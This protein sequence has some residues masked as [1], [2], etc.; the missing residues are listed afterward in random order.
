MKDWWWIPG[1]GTFLAL[2]ELVENNEVKARDARREME[3][4]DGEM[5]TAE[6][7]IRL[8]NTA[9]SQVGV[10]FLLRVLLLS[11]Q[12]SVQRETLNY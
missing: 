8:A 3:R 2:R 12:Q 5:S 9:I 4:Y 10:L 6:S 1:Y 11:R 7:N